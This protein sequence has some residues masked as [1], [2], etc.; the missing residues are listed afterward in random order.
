MP[1]DLDF[2]LFRR[3]LFIAGLSGVFCNKITCCTAVIDIFKPDQKIGRCIQFARIIQ[4]REISAGQIWHIHIGNRRQRRPNQ[5][6]DNPGNFHQISHV[7]TPQTDRR[8]PRAL[9]FLLAEILRRIDDDQ[10][11]MFAPRGWRHS[12]CPNRRDVWRFLC[13]LAQLKNPPEP[14]R[15]GIVRS[16]SLSPDFHKVVASNGGGCRSAGPHLGGDPAYGLCIGAPCPGLCRSHAASSC[17][18]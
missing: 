10:R 14:R 11:L 13:D 18:V 17:L 3:P 7:S 15:Q 4:R 6:P 12:S 8:T 2:H 1:L 9:L 16:T 5:K